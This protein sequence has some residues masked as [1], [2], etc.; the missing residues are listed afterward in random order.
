[1]SYER[2]KCRNELSL[3]NSGI[4]GEKISDLKILYLIKLKGYVRFLFSSSKSLLQ[5]SRLMKRGSCRHRKKTMK[6][7]EKERRKKKKKTTIQLWDFEALSDYF[8]SSP[9]F[10]HS[11]CGAS[12]SI[13][14]MLPIYRQSSIS[15]QAQV[16]SLFWEIKNRTVSL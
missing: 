14:S 1:M 4:K 10:S 13:F 5:L 6:N 15:L 8:Y 2:E 12:K 11:S 16:F 7:G 3:I 9:S